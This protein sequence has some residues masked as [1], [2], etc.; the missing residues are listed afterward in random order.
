MKKRIALCL[1]A[2]LM[3]ALCACVQIAP[4][5]EITGVNTG[6]TT[7][8]PDEAQIT[9]Q[10]ATQGATA[11]A[12]ATTRE[13]DWDGRKI[14]IAKTNIVTKDTADYPAFLETMALGWLA[15]ESRPIANSII[16]QRQESYLD[17]FYRVFYAAYPD[18]KNEISGLGADAIRHFYLQCS[19]EARDMP[20]VPNSLYGS[21]SVENY[22]HESFHY[23]AQVYAVET[24]GDYLSV[25]FFY[26]YYGGGA[27]GDQGKFADVFELKTGQRQEF[28]ELVHIPT[29]YGVINTL[30]EEYLRKENIEPFDPFDI[31]ENEP[32][33]FRMTKD[34]YVLIYNPYD[35]ASYADGIIE[36]PLPY[37]SF[38]E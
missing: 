12:A 9:T 17:V 2:A 23:R 16:V 28:G 37:T 5:Q 3:A 14:P 19:N 25:I 27:H 36:I 13:W 20:R 24:A 1:A 38:W 29:Y 21:D 30:A 15:E 4:K 31:R 33:S 18:F 22:E 32:S 11:Q 34:A 26:D 35:I 7:S 6:E 10:D 8:G